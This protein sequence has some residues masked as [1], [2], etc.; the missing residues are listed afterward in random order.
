MSRGRS[1][2]IF[3][4]AASA[5]VGLAFLE[6][7]APWTP[8][9]G[10]GSL[11]WVAGLVAVFP[12]GAAC[13]AIPIGLVLLLPA[14]TRGKGLTLASSGASFLVSFLLVSWLGAGLRT[15]AL[16]KT[17]DRGAT[18]IASIRQYEQAH[19]HPPP[20]LASLIPDYLGRIPTTGLGSSPVYEYD[21]RPD[22]KPVYGGKWMLF[23]PCSTGF[24]H[25]DRMVY[26]P[27]EDY[28][29][30]GHLGAVELVGRWGYLHE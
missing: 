25:I 20:E 28:S 26:L 13:L 21:A 17:A 29:V 11:A 4:V 16:V 9:P 3:A 10:V 30:L 22:G 24:I 8:I 27:S 18:L 2:V 6:S 5:G 7:V 14:R 15:R 1:R 23:V 19:G 12:L